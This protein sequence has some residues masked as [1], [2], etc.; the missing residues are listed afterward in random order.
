MGSRSSDKTMQA[1]DAPTTPPPGPAAV[2]VMPNAPGDA[3]SG[4]MSAMQTPTG[5]AA[6][7]PL[8][9]A[10][11][12]AAQKDAAIEQQ[13]SSES[14][15][16]QTPQRS[17]QSA[18]GMQQAGRADDAPAG[19]VWI[20][21]LVYKVDELAVIITTPYA[22]QRKCENIP[23]MKTKLFPAGPSFYK[24]TARTRICQRF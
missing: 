20:E 13:A 12:Q 7:T 9:S 19:I 1:S 21:L 11:Q 23:S 3:S 8:V 24:M 10:M 2:P 15:Q 5:T 16:E 17:A 14:S 22:L 4:P 6:T 18:A